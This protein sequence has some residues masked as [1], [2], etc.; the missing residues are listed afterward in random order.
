MPDESHIVYHSAAE[1]LLDLAVLIQDY[2]RQDLHIQSLKGRVALLERTIRDALANLD[3]AHRETL[4]REMP[5]WMLQAVA[6][7]DAA[8][9]QLGE[10]AGE[11]DARP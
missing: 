7:M 2:Q 10:I 8:R 1:A 4:G 11:R 6:L 9:Q 3:A 5:G